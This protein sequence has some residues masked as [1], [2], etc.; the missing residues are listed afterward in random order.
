MHERAKGKPRLR[1]LPYPTPRSDRC[2]ELMRG[3]I[4]GLGELPA[5]D[6]GLEDRVLACLMVAWG[7]V[8]AMGDGA[9]RAEILESLTPLGRRVVAKLITV[10]DLTATETGA[11]GQKL[12]D[13]LYAAAR[14]GQ[15]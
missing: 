9:R 2:Q 15:G 13:M 8:A 7:E 11:A 14:K 3:V 6:D 10:S 12:S 5:D 1:A 4:E